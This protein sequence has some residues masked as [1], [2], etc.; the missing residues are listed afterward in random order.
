MKECEESS[1][2][3]HSRKTS[4]LNLTTGKSPKVAHMW[5]MQGS[6]R[7][8]TA[9]VLQDKTSSLARQLARDSNSRLVPV[10]SSSRQNALFGCNWLFAFL[11]HSTINTL[12]SMKCR[13]LLEKI[14]KETLE[15]KQD[16]LIHNLHPLILQIPLLSP[17]P[18]RGT[19]SQ[20]LISPYP[21]KWRCIL[22]L[23]KQ[24]RRDQFIWLMQWAIVG[25]DKLKKTR[26]GVTLLEQEAWK[27]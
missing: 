17:F 1:R 14:L 22:V 24:F 20:I 13:E 25:S 26:F 7:V 27:A 19:F 18:L 23:G 15:K 2:C 9:G 3:V 4:R 11:I 16:W 8:T 10:A 6:W 12:I 5:S 21:Y